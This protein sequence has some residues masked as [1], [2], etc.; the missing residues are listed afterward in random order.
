[1]TDLAA[2]LG[3]EQLKK[4]AAFRDARVTIAAR[5][6]EAF[7][8]MPEIGRPARDDR[9]E[10]AWHLYVIRL[11]LDRLRIDRAQFIDALKQR[12]IGTSVHFIPLHLHPYYQRALGVTPAGFPSASAAYERIVSLP[13][14]PT[15][16]ADDVEDVI[17]AARITIEQHRR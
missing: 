8:A 3:I 7:A 4:A 14:F 11:D 12:N 13:I 1:M 6:D 9:S 10:H 17:E 16:S 2:A 15:M 5:Y